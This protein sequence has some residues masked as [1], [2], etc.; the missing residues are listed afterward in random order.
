MLKIGI[1][2][3]PNL[4]RLGIREPEIYGYETLNDLKH[5]LVD[6]SHRLDVDVDFFQSN[7]EGEMIDKIYEWADAGFFGMITNPGAY[8]HTSIAL[9]DAISSTNL[10]NVEV[11]ISNVYKREEFRHTSLTA[12]VSQ[13]IISG[14]G[15]YGYVAAL[16]YLAQAN[17][18]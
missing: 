18:K 2:N 4:N 15:F 13:G 5:I 12:P 17:H 8:T 1:L 11:H 16:H 7:H 3:G 10:K 14:L 6:E 9:R